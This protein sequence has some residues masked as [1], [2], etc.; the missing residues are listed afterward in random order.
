[1]CLFFKTQTGSCVLTTRSLAL[2]TRARGRWAAV[3]CCVARAHAL[4]PGNTWAPTHFV[5]ADGAVRS[6]LPAAASVLQDTGLSFSLEPHGGEWELGSQVFVTSSV[7]PGFAFVIGCSPWIQKDS[8][9][10]PSFP[11][12]RMGIFSSRRRKKERLLVSFWVRMLI[13]ISYHNSNSS[14]G[15]Q[16]YIDSSSAGCLGLHWA[17]CIRILEIGVVSPAVQ[18]RN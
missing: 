3:R 18:M 13:V 11:P 17:L 1:M 4:C 15:T 10:V 7:S 12:R 16:D 14:D 9:T 6:R 2:F 5:L 8:K